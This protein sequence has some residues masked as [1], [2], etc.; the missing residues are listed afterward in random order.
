MASP[1]SNGFSSAALAAGSATP[2][3]VARDEAAMAFK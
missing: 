3:T 2:T 1:G